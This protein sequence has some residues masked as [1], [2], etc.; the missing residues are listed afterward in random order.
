LIQRIQGE[1]K[2]RGKS[3]LWFPFVISHEI[4]RWENKRLY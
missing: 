4:N 2:N 3:C 1:L